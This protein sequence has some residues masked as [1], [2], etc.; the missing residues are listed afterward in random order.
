[1]NFEKKLKNNYFLSDKEISFPHARVINGK[2][3]YP[4]QN[5]ETNTSK[6]SKKTRNKIKLTR[7]EKKKHGMRY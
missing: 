4:K 2:S 1:M 6:N 5:N 7:F 3:N